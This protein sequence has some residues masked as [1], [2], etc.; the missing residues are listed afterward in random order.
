[1]PLLKYLTT[2]WLASLPITAYKDTLERQKLALYMILLIWIFS[3]QHVKY[4]V[5][6]IYTKQ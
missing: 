6:R 2:G 5:S 3:W 1:L 4:E